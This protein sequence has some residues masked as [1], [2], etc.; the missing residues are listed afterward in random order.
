[1]NEIYSKYQKW[2]NSLSQ[3]ERFAVRNAHSVNRAAK[4][5][6]A[7][8]ALVQELKEVTQ[9]S[10]PQSPVINSLLIL[11]SRRD[12]LPSWGEVEGNPMTQ[13]DV[14]K[15][16]GKSLKRLSP[17]KQTWTLTRLLDPR[18]LRRNEFARKLF[19]EALCDSEWVKKNVDV[20]GLFCLAFTGYEVYENEQGFVLDG[21]FQG[22]AE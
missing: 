4:V 6:G 12:T 3:T 17:N 11:A 2:F 20:V 15:R 19:Q 5:R 22:E 8:Y 18:L 16:L 14:L 7:R 10:D 13:R 9:I 1:M 21:H